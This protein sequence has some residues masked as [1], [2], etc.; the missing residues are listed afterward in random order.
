MTADEY[1]NSEGIRLLNEDGTLP[2]VEQRVKA[3]YDHGWVNGMV[4]ARDL[5]RDEIE[6]ELMAHAFTKAARL[7][8][9]YN[10]RNGK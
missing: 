3:G 4:T 8:A 1:W 6:R 9:E 10:R 7:L 2:T 5:D